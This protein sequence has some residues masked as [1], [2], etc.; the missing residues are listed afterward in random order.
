MSVAEI[1]WDL[2][3]AT[4]ICVEVWFLLLVSSRVPMITT[5]EG[6]TPWFVSVVV[7]A[8]QKGQLE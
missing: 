1:F 7:L 4:V 2:F 8:K 6:S 3:A 5:R